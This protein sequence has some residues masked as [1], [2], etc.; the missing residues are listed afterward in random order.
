[1]SEITPGLWQL[2]LSGLWVTVQ[3]TV[4]SAAL[5]GTVALVVGVART[6]RRW[7]V[8]FA[9]GCY[10]EVFRGMSALILMFWIFFVLPLGLGW[11][12]VPM[13]AAVLALGLTYGAYG[14][15]VVRGALAAVPAGQ[16]EAA[17]A[18]GFGPART[19]ARVLLPQAWPEM[20]RPLNNLLVELVKGTALVSVMGVSDLAFGAAL[21]RNATGQSAPVYTV[22]LVAYFL[23][24]FVL[25][26]GMRALERRARP[27]AV[28]PEPAPGPAPGTVP[29]PAVRT[30]ATAA[31]G[32]GERR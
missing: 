22:I 9:A 32:A 11:Q 16:R 14:S 1:M 25:T 24:A 2:L 12:L 3:L 28:P 6:H 10:F 23:L 30:P 18:L 20:I 29:P 17:L 21:V 15:E 13:W 4:G 5:G 19:T 26:R 31:P 7:I 27:G 8:R